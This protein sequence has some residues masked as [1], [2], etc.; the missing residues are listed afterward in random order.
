MSN[1]KFRLALLVLSFITAGTT[2]ST[3]AGNE[4]H[5]S[6]F[7]DAGPNPNANRA[8][9]VFQQRNADSEVTRAR[10]VHWNKGTLYAAQTAGARM[11][12]E[13]FQDLT[14]V[15]FVVE[16]SYI[17][18][19]GSQVWT[20]ADASRPGS[21]IILVRRGDVLVGDVRAPGLSVF[22]ISSMGDD[23][24]QYSRV[25][26][27]KPL[28]SNWCGT[29][30][31][32]QTRGCSWFGIGVLHINESVD[33]MVLYTPEAKAAAGG[34][35]SIE[36]H[37]E[38]N[39]AWMNQAF[40]NS[41]IDGAVRLV[42][43]AEVQY[44]EPH[45]LHETLC[46]LVGNEIPVRNDVIHDTECLLDH[47]GA[48]AMALLLAEDDG[49]YL[50]LATGMGEDLGGPSDGNQDAVYTTLVYDIPDV[51]AHEV[52]HILGAGH[53]DEYGFW[54]D[55]RAYSFEI[56]N[57][58]YRSIMM[59]GY[60]EGSSTRIGIPY[61]SNPDVTFLGQPTGTDSFENA[62]ALNWTCGIAANY[63]NRQ[64]EWYYEFAAQNGS[65]WQNFGWGISCDGRWL[66]VRQA[67]GYFYTP[68]PAL[69]RVVMYF[70]DTDFLFGCTWGSRPIYFP[71]EDVD[72][73]TF[74]GDG[75]IDTD[76][77]RVIFSTFGMGQDD[78]AIT[79]IY[80]YDSGSDQF[81]LEAKLTDPL[82]SNPN[83][84]FGSQVAIEGN[85]AVVSDWWSNSSICVFRRNTSNGQWVF[86][87]NLQGL[88]GVIAGGYLPFSIHDGKIAVTLPVYSNTKR[89]AIIYRHDNHVGSWVVDQVVVQDIPTACCSGEPDA[90]G[91]VMNNNWLAV[92]RGSRRVH[93]EGL[94]GI[95]AGIDIYR[96]NPDGPVGGQ[97]VFHS[98]LE[99]SDVAPDGEWWTQL[100]IDLDSNMLVVG[101]NAATVD[102]LVQRGI[103]HI[104]EYS[105][106]TD[107][108]GWTESFAGPP[109]EYG[110]FAYSIA[111][112]R[113]Y[114]FAS[115]TSTTGVVPAADEHVRIYY[116]TPGQSQGVPDCTLTI[117]DQPDSLVIAEGGTAVFSVAATADVNPT[118]SYQ[119]LKDGVHLQDN[120]SPP[121]SQTAYIV[122]AHSST[123]TITNVDAGA[124][125]SYECWVTT[126]GCIRATNIAVL[127]LLPDCPADLTG[128]TNKPDGQV[129]V[130]D[131]FYL[132]ANWNT[133]GPG[134]DL[135][136]PINI[137][138]VSDLFA[139]LAA[140]GACP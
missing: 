7:T 119:W 34:V 95:Q 125:G 140:W 35:T 48:D 19:H 126:P 69:G 42:R 38:L 70:K 107:S 87:Q 134:A 101:D 97:W 24:P 37:I 59:A 127:S 108:W 82:S 90:K 79:Y 106:A 45:D 110:R 92:A 88:S 80:K 13:L 84:L 54:T 53:E 10:L 116:H 85:I 55:S 47:H 96:L 40:D 3:A 68:A 12:I 109:V 128:N 139:L 114:V 133:N 66:A 39:I 93:P 25:E 63:E 2:W 18:N 132:L 8:Q 98:A 33:L 46:A 136:P 57:I 9:H 105:P 122:D 15:D 58:E 1:R 62:R 43:M 26:E 71:L 131:L 28:P 104:A 41:D 102:S 50:G 5:R 44:T 103:V 56:G 29:V 61:F 4:S 123:L 75:P 117:T 100:R 112:H 36:S 23:L 22:S 67:W 65:E 77:D 138:N 20:G 17:T 51:F 32:P 74:Q 31:D 113:S 129:N 121:G 49:E 27:R 118:F 60:Y 21:S 135:A 91:V 86:E 72:S 76:G 81:E 30:S 64:P 89:G 14:P 137:V 73:V 83:R 111:A 99:I 115:H 124:T 120:T 11:R 16:K 6:L 130:S 94:P 78:D 52:G